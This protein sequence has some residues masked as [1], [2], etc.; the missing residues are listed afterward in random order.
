MTIGDYTAFKKLFQYYFMHVNTHPKS[1]L[2]R[3]YGV[4]SVQMED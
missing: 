2:A 1:L 3:I 4:Y